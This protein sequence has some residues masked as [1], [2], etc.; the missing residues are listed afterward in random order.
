MLKELLEQFHS[1]QGDAEKIKEQ[2]Y[3][4]KEYIEH[5][6]EDTFRFHKD[7]KELMKHL[8][9]IT[10]LQ[11]FKEHDE[12][13]YTKGWMFDLNGNSYT[14]G[15]MTYRSTTDYFFL[16]EG[17]DEYYDDKK[18]FNMWKIND[19][20]FHYEDEDFKEKEPHK[21]IACF[22]QQNVNPEFN[23]IEDMYL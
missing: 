18:S 22:L 17:H 16:N 10:Y 19:E 11:P 1:S 4:S 12:D 20:I 21:I 14:V 9:N 3:S 7:K 13:E 8:K 2:I 23:E 6:L 15:M 5:V